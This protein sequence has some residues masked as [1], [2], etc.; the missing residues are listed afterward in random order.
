MKYV[1]AMAKPN[2]QSILDKICAVMYCK[3]E[4]NAVA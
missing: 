4:K 2:G 1:W 3:K